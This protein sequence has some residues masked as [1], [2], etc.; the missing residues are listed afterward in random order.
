MKVLVVD[1]DDLNR[2]IL[3]TILKDSGFEVREVSDG[4]QA[5]AALEA[6][7]DIQIIL[8]DR[9]MPAMN[10]IEFMEEFSRRAEWAYKKVIMQ[11][12]ANQPKDVISGKS[13]GV[14]YYLVKPFDDTILMSVVRAAADEIEKLRS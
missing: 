9:M 3:Q 12:A 10:G 5:I 2:K 8:L 11:T 7:P 4:K 6:E 13:T 14:Y 1:D